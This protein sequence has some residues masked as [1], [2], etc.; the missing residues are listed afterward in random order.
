MVLVD[1]IS[2]VTHLI[3]FVFINIILYIHIHLEEYVSCYNGCCIYLKNL[4]IIYKMII[5]YSV[6][7]RRQVSHWRRATYI[8]VSKVVVIESN[9]GALARWCQPII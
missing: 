5:L 2:C 7:I 8:C 4:Y 6:F 1:I 3:I 9:I